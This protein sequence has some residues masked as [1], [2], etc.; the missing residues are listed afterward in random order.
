[1]PIIYRLRFRKFS[2]ECQTKT[3]AVNHELLKYFYFLPEEVGCE[4]KIAH[5]PG[6][7]PLSIQKTVGQKNGSIPSTQSLWMTCFAGDI[8]ML[9]TSRAGLKTN[10]LPSAS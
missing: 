4:F 6:I 10:L 5:N 8:W 3:Q 9:S 7:L 1:M 2:K